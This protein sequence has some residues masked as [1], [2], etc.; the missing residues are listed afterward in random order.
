VT[1]PCQHTVH[2]WVRPRLKSDEYLVQNPD[3]ERDWAVDI[4]DK[5]AINI[6]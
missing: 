2:G 6:I 1:P 5:R 4:C 3:G